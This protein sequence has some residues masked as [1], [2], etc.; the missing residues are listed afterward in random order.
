[1]SIIQGTTNNPDINKGGPFDRPVLAADPQRHAIYIGA[2]A[3]YFEDTKDRES[4]LYISKDD[5]ATFRKFHLNTGSPPLTMVTDPDGVLYAL[6]TGEYLAQNDMRIELMK[7]TSTSDAITKV[8]SIVPSRVTWTAK[9]TNTRADDKK[10]LIW[11]GP[12]ILSD[13]SLLSPHYGRLYLIWSQPKRVE[14][15]PSTTI[16][17]SPYGIDFDIKMA[18]S[19]DKAAHWSEPKKVDDDSTGA[20]QI[21]PSAVLDAKGGL[22]IAFLDHRG[23]LDVPAMD[24]YYTESL[25]GGETFT[26]NLKVN[27]RSMIIDLTKWSGSRFFGDYSNMV[28][29]YPDRSLIAFPCDSGTGYDVCMTEVGYPTS[30]MRPVRH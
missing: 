10:Y 12:V 8:T 6:H 19:D 29:G 27:G 4:G 23:A 17:N 9:I 22:H 28:A 18:Y 2:N 13:N 21:F 7:I 20:D 30:R 14:P 5:G 26:P 16:D 3:V 1:V 15:G 25:D 24:V 11:P